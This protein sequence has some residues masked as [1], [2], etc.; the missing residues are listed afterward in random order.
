MTDWRSLL[1]P[2]LQQAGALQGRITDSRAGWAQA[3]SPIAAPAPIGPAAPAPMGAPAPVPREPAAPS[4]R[5]VLVGDSLGVGTRPYLHGVRAADTVVGRSSANGVSA[6]R[7]IVAHGGAGRVLFDL[8]TNDAS[9]GQLASSLRQARRIAPDAQFIVPTVN[10]PGASQKN[11]LLRQL[12]DR[13]DITLVDW[14]GRSR[15][16]VGGDGIHASAAGYKRRAAL[17]AAA[18]GR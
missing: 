11:A 4:G 9:A 15:G 18:L 12:A 1:D 2:M 10:G 16:L 7:Q 14:A 5:T 17:I 13:G 3:P 8:G 6:L